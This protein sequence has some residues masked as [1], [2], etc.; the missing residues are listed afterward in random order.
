MTAIETIKGIS[1]AVAELF[2]RDGE[3]FD[4]GTEGIN[5]QTLTFRLGLYLAQEFKNQN[6]DCEYNRLWD[7]TK[8]RS[9]PGASLFRMVVEWTHAACVGDAPVLVDDVNALGPRGVGI[10]RGVRHIV[11]P[12]GHRIFEPLDEI[13]GDSDALLQRFGLR[14]ADVFFHVR[15]HLPF[16]GGMRLAY[17]DR[18]K[19]GVILIVVVNLNDVADLAT[20]RRSS[21]AAEDHHERPRT[22]AF[23][24]VKV[25]L[26]I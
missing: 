21:V 12:E 10:V 11:D 13:I 25:I 20:K 3:L 22:S 19:V 17:V 14:V 6:V 24:Q 26:A 4:L 23:A 18:Q 15:F 5:G 8:S 1:N 2:R 16:V 7:R 9:Q